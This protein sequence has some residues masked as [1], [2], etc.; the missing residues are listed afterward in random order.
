MP[1]RRSPLEPRV[2]EIM[3]ERGSATVREVYEE[4]RKERDISLTTVGTVLSRLYGKGFLDREFQTGRGGVFYVYRV[5]VSREEYERKVAR[6]AV[7]KIVTTLG[8]PALV[9]LIEEGAVQLSLEELREILRKI[10]AE[11]ARAEREGKEG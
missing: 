8:R 6:D 2:M 7:R 11:K 1:R 10:E 3:F 4:L 5:K 9:R